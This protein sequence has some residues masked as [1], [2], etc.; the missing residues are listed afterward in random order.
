MMRFADRLRQRLMA[1]VLLL[2]ST[3][4][5]P[6]ARAEE[7]VCPICKSA[8]SE[9]ASYGETAGHTF[10]RGASNLFFG[11]TEVIHRPAYEARRGGNAFT[12]V[13]D[14]A[15]EGAKR[16]VAGLG[17]LLTFWM[18]KVNDRYIRF[19]RDCPICMGKTQRQPP[20]TEARQSPAT[21]PPAN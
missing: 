15:R 6:A 9:T 4:A 16:T 3:A 13:G 5:P 18:P 19:S 7:V 20:S 12:A 14:G 8:G 10:V 1:G 2:A 17:E 11:W 21:P